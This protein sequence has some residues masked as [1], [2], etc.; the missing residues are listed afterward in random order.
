MKWLYITV[1]LICVIAAVSTAFS[2]GKF[3][4]DANIYTL[5]A[6][7]LVILARLETIEEKIK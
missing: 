1:A 4:A 6:L 5:G 3:T 7:L 2:Y